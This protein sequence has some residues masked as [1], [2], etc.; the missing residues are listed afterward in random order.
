MVPWNEAVPVIAVAI[1]E[2][3]N[4]VVAI[5][6][7]FVP[8]VAVGAFGVPVNVGLASGARVVSVGCT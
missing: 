4:Y 3:T 7:L 6:V 2:V 1:A 5:Y 8:A